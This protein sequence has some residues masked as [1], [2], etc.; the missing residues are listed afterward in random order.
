MNQVKEPKTLQLFFLSY[1]HSIKHEIFE[2]LV[3]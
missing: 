1:T 3:L 2:S